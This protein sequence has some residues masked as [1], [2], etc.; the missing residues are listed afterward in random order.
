[1]AFFDDLGKKIT[2]TSKNVMNKAKGM[3]DITDLKSQI[4]NEERKINKYCQNLGHMYYDLKKDEPLPE[5]AELV[6]LING[7]Y[8]QIEAI[9]AQI[10]SIENV[11]TCP[12]C[13]AALENDMAFCVGCG[14]KIEKA[15]M[16]NQGMQAPEGQPRF[17]VNCGNQLLPGAIFCTKCGTKQS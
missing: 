6:S 14:T 16:Q 8:S 9:N 12:V 17:C 5:L 2:V 15:P 11:K 10:A 13:G 3:V 1:M 7:S 4:S